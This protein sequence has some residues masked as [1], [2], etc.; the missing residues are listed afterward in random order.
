MN[1][2]ETIL[3]DVIFAITPLT[4]YLFYLIFQ[5][6]TEQKEN[7]LFLDIALLSSLYCLLR[8]SPNE[9]MNSKALLLNI[10]LVIA[11]IKKRT[12]MILLISMIIS[13]FSAECFSISW[14]FFTIEYLGYF[15]LYYWMN[16]KTLGKRSFLLT[17]LL[18]KS[19]VFL[20]TFLY[21]YGLTPYHIGVWIVLYF[22]FILSLYFSLQVYMKCEDVSV[23]FINVQNQEQEKKLKSNLFRITHEIKNP[24]AV[25]KGYLD[26]FDVHNKEHSEKYIPI[27]KE[28]INRTLLLLQDFLSISKIRLDKDYMDVN[29]LIEDV[30]NNFHL[31]M[32]EKHIKQEVELLDDDIYIMGDYNRLTQVFINLLKNSMEAIPVDRTGVIKVKTSVKDKNFYVEIEDNGDGITKDILAKIEEPFFTTKTNGTGLGVSL[33][34]EIIKAHEGTIVYDSTPFVGTKVKIWLPIQE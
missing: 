18:L 17:F 4:F 23:Y 24:I 7:N 21:V 14:I 20:G 16:Y 31:M 8:F 32:K 3:V 1:I 6:N 28:E 22:T 2:F 30:L 13:L 29:V 12:T 11:F 25:C 10:P 26:M 5:R 27:M 33:S 19:F 34:R 15:G 9:M